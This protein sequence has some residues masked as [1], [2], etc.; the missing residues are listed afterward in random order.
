[1]T[2]PTEE[3]LPREEELRERALA[4]MRGAYA[5]YSRFHVGAA[6]LCGDEVVA[7]CNVENASY[8]AC[9]CAE[10]TAVSAAVAAGHRR[11]DAL[12]LATEAETPTPPCGICRQILGEFSPALPILSITTGGTEKRWTLAELLPYP[13]S[14]ASLDAPSVRTD[15][16]R[17]GAP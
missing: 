10:R 13:F 9:T 2:G 12:V 5:P 16:A 4:A 1:M 15:P 8:P 17:R 11:F 14:P 3:R 6:L 7:G